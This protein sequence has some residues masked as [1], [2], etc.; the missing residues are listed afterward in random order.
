MKT[1][2]DLSTEISHKIES[3]NDLCTL[4]EQERFNEVIASLESLSIPNDDLGN[5]I[6]WSRNNYTRNCILSSPNFELLLLCWEPGQTTGIH[7]HDEQECWVKVI[8]GSF[9][10]TVYQFEAEKGL[11]Q[12]CFRK[13]LKSTQISNLEEKSLF[14]KLENNGQQRGISLHL[15]FKPITKCEIFN[16]ATQSFSH[17]TP[18][19]HSKFGKLVID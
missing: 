4:L 12:E 2:T 18:T 7:S 14:H 15:Y 17:Y 11:M 13:S 3:L 5:Y 19:Y 6:F 10:E 9:V 1:S 16:E 8:S